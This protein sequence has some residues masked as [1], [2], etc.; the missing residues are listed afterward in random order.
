M[1]KEIRFNRKWSEDEEQALCAM[2]KMGSS[3]KEISV[4]LGRTEKAVQIKASCMARQPTPAIESVSNDVQ[5]ADLD[6]LLWFVREAWN[7][8]HAIVIPS[9]GATFQNGR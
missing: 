5:K 3:Y 8:G 1:S 7:E 4:T 2:K 9:L 6:L